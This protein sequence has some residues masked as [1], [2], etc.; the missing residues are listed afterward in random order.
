MTPEDL[1]NEFI[2]AQAVPAPGANPT[3]RWREIMERTG[4]VVDE[5]PSRFDRGYRPGFA[6][7][8]NRGVEGTYFPERNPYQGPAPLGG[9]LFM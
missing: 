4:N 2:L 3:P 1:L 7:Q 5:I 8:F 6:D 9:G